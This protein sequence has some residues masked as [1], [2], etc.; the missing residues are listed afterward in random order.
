M[1]K[2]II[3]GNWKMN[4]TVGEAVE[5]AREL[6]AKDFDSGRVQVVI[7][8]PFT[9][10]TAVQE[11][12]QGSRIELGAQDLYWEKS[13]AFTG[14]I[15]ADMLV[16]AGCAYVIIGHSERRQYFSE[17]DETVNLKLVAAL[18]AGLNPIVCVGEMLDERQ[19][20]ETES[21]VERQIRGAFAGLTA[22]QAQKAVI[23][24]EPVWA[25]GTGQVATPDQAQEVHG[26]IRALIREIYGDA[27]ADSMRIQ[28]GGSMK[29][30]NASELLRQPD[31][32]GGLI[33]GASLD[34]ESF[35]AIVKAE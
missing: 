12:L 24:Y 26:F 16:S 1:R 34:A 2:K 3:A 7:C 35:W 32:D 28:Y 9:D 22:E 8:P 6:A 13:G 18:Q 21:V 25:I 11:T 4:K 15:S 14:Q 23:A 10:L 5:L 17:T 31:V 29:A 33:G 27:V 19:N 30:N 20:D